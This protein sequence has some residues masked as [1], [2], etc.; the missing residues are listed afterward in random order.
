[1]VQWTSPFESVRKIGLKR[2]LK[3]TLIVVG[4]CR[5]WE[6]ENC[7]NRGCFPLYLNNQRRYGKLEAIIRF[8]V[9]NRSIYLPN[10]ILIIVGG[11]SLVSGF[12]NTSKIAEIGAGF[13]YT[14]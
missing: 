5:R 2:P 1:M 4:R 9:S 13:H 10:V 11:R 8:S 14:S 12:K 6:T 3:S 7:E